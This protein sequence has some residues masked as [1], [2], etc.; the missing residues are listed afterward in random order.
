MSE[1]LH[2]SNAA[3]A[4]GRGDNGEPVQGGSARHRLTVVSGPSGVGKSSV[5]AEL[6]RLCPDIY[7]SV[8]VTTRAPRAGEVDGEHY[9]FVDPETF[10]TMATGG[11]LL[12]HAEFAGNRYGTPRA[13]VERVLDGGRPAVLEIELKG[14]RQ[15]RRAM[16]E[17][18]LVMLLPPSWEDLVGRLTG[19]GTEHDDAVRARLREAESE[20]AA[21]EEFDARVVNADVRA[22]ARELLSLVVGR[23]TVCDE[24]EHSQ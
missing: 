15:V 4:A 19:R 14:A 11:E 22:A 18:Q 16:P 24:T 6:R 2:G 3:G 5:V 13:P 23:N 10:E 21:A 9:H 17:A 7:F 8:S 20:L 1:R 12:E